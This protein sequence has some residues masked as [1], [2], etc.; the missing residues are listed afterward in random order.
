VREKQEGVRPVDDAASQRRGF[1]IGTF[2]GAFVVSLLGGVPLF[3]ALLFAAVVR[4]FAARARKS[5]VRRRILPPL[6]MA[7]LISALVL[8]LSA[9]PDFKEERDALAQ[10]NLARSA[11]AAEEPVRAMKALGSAGLLENESVSI[12]VLSSCVDWN[13]QYHD[14]ALFEA[15]VALNLGY[16]PE[17]ESHYLGRGCF[18]DTPDFHGVDFTRI[19]PVGWQLYPS[20]D[21]G[22]ALGQRFLDI[23]VIEA[24]SRPGDQ[25]VALGCLADRYDLRSLAAYMFTVGLNTNLRLGL[26]PTPFRALRRCL[27]DKSIA[28]S[29]VFRTNPYDGTEEFRPVDLIARIPSPSRSTPPDSCWARFPNNGP[30]THR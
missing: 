8:A 29:Y 30:C 25:F 10:L 14:W 1:A 13:L 19:E 20:P 16:R 23:A 17:E 2:L 27:N 28:A 7:G 9:A 15:Q 4:F 3:I 24:A 26:A 18:L 6:A 22:D 5:E 11:I 21:R 12:T